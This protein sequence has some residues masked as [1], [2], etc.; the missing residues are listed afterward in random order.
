[1]EKSE[2]AASNDWVCLYCITDNNDGDEYCIQCGNARDHP[3]PADQA[4]P[5]D[6]QTEPIYPPLTPGLARELELASTFPDEPETHH[7]AEAAEERAEDHTDELRAQAVETVEVS[8]E[9][10]APTDG[11]APTDDAPTE[12]LA[13]TDASSTAGRPAKKYSRVAPFPPLRGTSRRGR[14]DAER[15]AVPGGIGAQASPRG[16]A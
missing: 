6:R 4:P 14:L 7:E 2:L 3:P 11:Q 5:P 13:H 9:D 1:M 10:D 15:G 16:E 12:G 8:D